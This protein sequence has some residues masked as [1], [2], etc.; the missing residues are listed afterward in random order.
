MLET[1]R[2]F[3]R[4]GYQNTTP[5]SRCAP[6]WRSGSTCDMGDDVSAGHLGLNRLVP[7]WRSIGNTVRR[8]R[9][10][11]LRTGSYLEDAIAR[12]R[13]CACIVLGR[14]PAIGVS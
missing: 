12:S 9:T 7:A 10:E 8:G 11:V 14:S 1:L 2:K 6:L 5:G 4:G 13:K 3:H